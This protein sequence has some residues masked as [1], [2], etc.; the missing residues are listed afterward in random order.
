MSFIQENNITLNLGLNKEYKLI[1]ISD[2]HAITY[3]DFDSKEVIDEALKA[4]DLWYRQ[5]IW[6]ANKANE[7]CDESQMIPSKECLFSLIDYINIKKPA[8]AILSGDIIDYYSS[9][10]YKMLLEATKKIEVPYLFSCGNHETPTERFEE[11]TKNHLGFSLLHFDEFKIVSLN[12]SSKCISLETLNCFKKELE[13]NKPTIVVMHIPIATKFNQEEMKKYDPYF[14][15]YENETDDITKEFI[16]I[17]I[18]N[19][20]V[21]AILCGHVHGHNESYFA[22]NKM[23]LCASSGLIGLVNIVTIK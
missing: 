13:D 11:I 22:P 19:T 21:K 2:V 14:V 7:Y 20:N 16:D 6:F 8:A 5:R 15:I 17:L 9:S 10:N 12:N 4:E 1:H 3:N 18:N 23:Q